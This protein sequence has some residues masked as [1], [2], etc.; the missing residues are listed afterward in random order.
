VRAPREPARAIAWIAGLLLASP[1]AMAAVDCAVGA[2]GV[3]F[4]VYDPLVATADDSTGT[5]TVTCSYIA[6][7]PTA[8]ASYTV[9]LSPGASGVYSQRRMQAGTSQLGYNLF[10]DAARTQ[11]WGNAT[12]GTTIISGSMR[13]G[14]GVGNGTRTATHTVYGRV[15][16]GQDAA[17]GTYSDSILVTLTF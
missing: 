8:D 16:A 12:G 5:I 6:P 2:T 10:G 17:P 7:G 1:H 14:P 11:V 9:T 15:P 13:L 4:G 3:A